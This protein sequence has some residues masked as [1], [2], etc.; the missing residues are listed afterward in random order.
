MLGSNLFASSYAPPGKG[1]HS[2]PPLREVIP[3]SQAEY[4][5]CSYCGKVKYVA[6][7]VVTADGA[8]AVSC[9]PCSDRG[10]NWLEQNF[11]TLRHPV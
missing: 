2:C 8:E 11:P 4:A 3:A 6:Y 7:R 9:F 10:M 1:K 5:T